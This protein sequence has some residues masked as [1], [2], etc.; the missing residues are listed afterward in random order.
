MTGSNK[1]SPVKMQRDIRFTILGQ[2]GVGKSALVVRYLTHR[3][4]G[5]YDPDL[6]SVYSQPTRIDDQSITLHVL[7]TAGEFDF[8]SSSR[9]EQIRGSDA[10]VLV[11]SVTDRSSFIYLHKLKRFIFKSRRD[12]DRA[13]TLIIGNKVDLCHL[14]KVTTQE[15][16]QLAKDYGCAYCEM[17]ASEG[18]VPVV[19]AFH[20]LYREFYRAEKRAKVKKI[21]SRLQL[22][23]TIKNFTDRHL[24]RSRTN[25]L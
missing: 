25:T 1:Q 5:D 12:L 18:F 15:G 16:V 13:P 22:R 8:E 9:I 14:R 23:Q 17:S 21:T 10:F 20:D 11:Y 3:Y 4:I 24:Y 7:D 2:R 19:D 6:E